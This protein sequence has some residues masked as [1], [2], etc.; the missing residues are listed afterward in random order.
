[1]Q[2]RPLTFVPGSEL[3]LV[4]GDGAVV[5]RAVVERVSGSADVVARLSLFDRNPCSEEVRLL[6]ELAHACESL[7]FGAM[8]AIECRLCS[9][10]FQFR[11]PGEGITLRLGTDFGGVVITDQA[12]RI[13][14][15]LTTSPSGLSVRERRAPA[16]E[17]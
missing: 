15:R 2:A 6:H 8:N 16:I 14:F 4:T 1:M 10:G 11:V 12:G 13:A 5:G 3:L 9:A 17:S 7:A